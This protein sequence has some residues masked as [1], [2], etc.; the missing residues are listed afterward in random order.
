MESHAVIV[1]KAAH[2][3]MIGATGAMEFLLGIMA[4][5]DRVA[6]LVLNYLRLDPTHLP[7]IREPSAIDRRALVPNSFAFGGWNAVLIGRAA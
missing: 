4:L 1:T 6:L 5:G 2:G 7:P 3:H